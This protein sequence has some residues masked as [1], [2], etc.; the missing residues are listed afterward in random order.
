MIK[1]PAANT[2]LARAVRKVS[3]DFRQARV[4]WDSEKVISNAD[5]SDDGSH[6][7]V[8]DEPLFDED[9]PQSVEP[10]DLSENQNGHEY[11]DTVA[12][13]S[14][15]LARIIQLPISIP[16]KKASFDLLQQWECTVLDIKPDEFIAVARDR[17]DPK[18]PDEE[19]V[20]SYEDV[21]DYDLTLLKP[22]AVFYWNIGYRISDWGQKTKG[23]ELRF[24]RLPAWSKKEIDAVKVR[25]AELASLF[26]DDDDV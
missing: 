11:E 20:F 21:N 6:A 13:L 5:V 23:S 2:I 7:L 9:E 1:S 17:T 19:I 14:A 15:K 25:A 4:I 12:E 10:F 26:S 18:R 3:D 24:R 16:S 22:G 8:L